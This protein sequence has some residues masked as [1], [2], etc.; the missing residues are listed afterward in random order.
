MLSFAAIAPH[1]A[2]AIP[3]ISKQGIE[4]VAQ[5]VNGFQLLRQ[6]LYNSKPDVLIFI[7]P[8]VADVDEVF[9]INQN[10]QLA[11]NLKEFGDLTERYSLRN[12]LGLGYQIRERVESSFPVRLVE[13][14]SL[15]YGSAISHLCLAPNLRQVP[16]VIIGTASNLDLT[17]HFQFGQAILGALDNNTQRIAVIASAD[18]SHDR[19]DQT[20]NDAN[21]KFDRQ[22]I[23]L[24][25]QNKTTQFLNLPSDSPSF[26]TACGLRPIALLM[27]LL[28]NKNHRAS[29]VSYERSVGIGYANI[30]IRII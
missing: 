7:T 5:T 1:P 22:I 4:K 8:H 26:K 28:K 3:E 9:T 6:E 19:A 25:E 24:I 10:T 29:V 30:L 23:S 13:N 18:L 21:V 2:I 11:L 16:I 12:N 17:T 27:G 20:D 14:L 15:D